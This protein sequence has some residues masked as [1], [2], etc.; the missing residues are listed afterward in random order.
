[1]AGLG[2]VS[3]VHY[4]RSLGIEGPQLYRYALG[5]LPNTA[6]AVALPFAFISIWSDQNPGSTYSSTRRWFG[7]ASV[8]SLLGLIAWEFLQPSRGRIFDLHDIA[9]TIIGIGLAWLIFQVVT[10]NR[11]AA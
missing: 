2:V 4:A 7:L 1:M 10:P 5:V 9:A 11:S 6:A 3:L 8:V